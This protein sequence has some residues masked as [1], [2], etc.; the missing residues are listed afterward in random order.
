MMGCNLEIWATVSW[1]LSGYFIGTMEVSICPVEFQS[2]RGPETAL[3]L[4]HLPLPLLRSSY[5]IPV[6]PLCGTVWRVEGGGGQLAFFIHRSRN[7]VEPHLDI[8]WSKRTQT[9]STPKLLSLRLSRVL[10]LGDVRNNEPYFRIRVLGVREPV[11]GSLSHTLPQIISL[12][13]RQR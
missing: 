8:L 3:T 7:P 13:K 1:L 10:G 11:W 9:L 12:E 2:C 5:S 6:L 4:P